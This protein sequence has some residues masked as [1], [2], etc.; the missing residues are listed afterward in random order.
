LDLSKR[1]SVDEFVQNV[2]KEFPGH[3]DQLINNSG[4]MVG[5]RRITE[6]GVEST[7]AINHFGHF[8]LTYLL[9]DQLK[10]AK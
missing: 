10:K 9:F 1:A 4:L 8:Y 6:I 2:K 3:I 7:I 5:D